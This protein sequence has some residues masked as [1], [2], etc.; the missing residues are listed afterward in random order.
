MPYVRRLSYSETRLAEQLSVFNARLDAA[1]ICAQRATAVDISTTQAASRRRSRGVIARL[2]ERRS[3]LD[4]MLVEQIAEHDIQLRRQRRLIMASVTVAD[5]S[6]SR[7]FTERVAESAF[8][9]AQSRAEIDYFEARIDAREIPCSTLLS[10]PTSDSAEDCTSAVVTDVAAVRDA[11]GATMLMGGNDDNALVLQRAFASFPAIGAVLSCAKGKTGDMPQKAT[12]RVRTAFSTRV[13]QFTSGFDMRRVDAYAKNAQLRTA[14]HAAHF[15]HEH[16][17]TAA[18]P[19]DAARVAGAQALTDALIVES[20]ARLAEAT[21]TAHAALLLDAKTARAR[22]AL[23]SLLEGDS[24]RDER[25]LA[26]AAVNVEATPTNRTPSASTARAV[27]CIS[28]RVDTHSAAYPQFD[29]AVYR[30]DIDALCRGCHEASDVAASIATELSVLNES[31]AELLTNGPAICLDA[32]LRVLVVRSR[33]GTESR[34]GASAIHMRLA[35]RLRM[36]IVSPIDVLLAS[37]AT[38]DAWLLQNGT[39]SDVQ[40]YSIGD[41]TPNPIMT[42]LLDPSLLHARALQKA[43]AMQLTCGDCCLSP[44]STTAAALSDGGEGYVALLELGAVLAATLDAVA[45][46]IAYNVVDNASDT[47]TAPAQTCVVILTA[48]NAAAVKT[49]INVREIAEAAASTVREALAAVAALNCVPSTCVAPPML[50]KAT[51]SAHHKPAPVSTPLVP[52]TTFAPLF[53]T[54]SELDAV[55]IENESYANYEGLLARLV[56]LP[57]YA[58]ALTCVLRYADAVSIAASAKGI[59][60]HS[61]RSSCDQLP[62]HAAT[63]PAGV[64]GLLIAAETLASSAALV[65]TLHTLGSFT[66]RNTSSDSVVAAANKSQATS[67]LSGGAVTAAANIAAWDSS[68]DDLI[69]AHAAGTWTLPRCGYKP[70]LQWETI[71]RQC[72]DDEAA[73]ALAAP[74]VPQKGVNGNRTI[75][76]AVKLPFVRPTHPPPAISTLHAVLHLPPIEVGHPCDD[77]SAVLHTDV[78]FVTGTATS[79]VADTRYVAEL[80]STVASSCLPIVASSSVKV[81]AKLASTTAVPSATAQKKLSTAIAAAKS[82]HESVRSSIAPLLRWRAASVLLPELLQLHDTVVES[83]T[84][85]SAAIVRWCSDAAP[86]GVIGCTPQIHTLNSTGGAEHLSISQAAG[87]AESCLVHAPIE[88]SCVGIPMTLA[89]RTRLSVLLSH[90]R[91]D[92][93]ALH[94]AQR[95]VRLNTEANVAAQLV[96]LQVPVQV[97]RALA[98]AGSALHIRAMAHLHRSLA[99]RRTTFCNETQIIS[100]R[101]TYRLSVEQLAAELQQCDGKFEPLERRL[102]GSTIITDS[103]VTT[104]EALVLGA[105]SLHQIFLKAS[106]AALTEHSSAMDP[107]SASI[108]SSSM[109]TSNVK[110]QPIERNDDAVVIAA[111]VAL[112]A[113]VLDT[114]ISA[115]EALRVSDKWAKDSACAIERELTTVLHSIQIATKNRL[116]TEKDL[117]SLYRNV[118]YAIPFVTSDTAAPSASIKNHNSNC[119]SEFAPSS[120]L[121]SAS[122]R[123]GDPVLADDRAILYERVGGDAIQQILRKITACHQRFS[124]IR[125]QELEAWTMSKSHAIDALI[126]EII[127]PHCTTTSKSLLCNAVRRSYLLSLGSRRREWMLMVTRACLPWEIATDEVSKDYRLRSPLTADR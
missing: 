19:V 72:E 22:A 26:A 2:R 127:G 75:A 119:G 10:Q 5:T 120:D 16:V 38:L 100:R 39:S 4:S 85:P 108:Q 117:L 97:T 48:A 115:S 95:V 7:L 36:L 83:P 106:R 79:R 78:D 52:T 8:T 93:N 11:V 24:R 62:A 104:V 6:A 89:F 84:E 92:V 57:V 68:T 123:L 12:P 124:I 73:A 56:G 122:E 81:G 15:I 14:Q 37:A 58:R 116:D 21:T 88:R 66:S 82:A 91:G 65:A 71:C 110:L 41:S 74:I 20:A 45:S 9:A 28:P 103:G 125:R 69:K 43:A 96:C 59:L 102:A 30:D 112:W 101:N 34:L 32:P 55:E 87:N 13:Q 23:K 17:E 107:G 44:I 113:I 99:I 80:D 31:S 64:N 121:L 98:A 35:T 33:G 27:R 109:E 47:M 67:P 63:L 111:R 40:Q 51:L 25:L 50:V 42:G 90:A 3:S 86:A 70:A 18:V 49:S 60:T 105:R 77:I 126:T 54:A 61:S 1:R 76:T 94:D 114:E 118:G 53:C 46:R 29:S